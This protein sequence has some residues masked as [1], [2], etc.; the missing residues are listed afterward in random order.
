[1]QATATA[2][3]ESPRRNG[4]LAQ[5]LPGGWLRDIVRS[6][7]DGA[8]M[9][10]R[11]EIVGTTSRALADCVCGRS[12]LLS[13]LGDMPTRAPV[14]DRSSDHRVFDVETE[15]AFKNHVAIILGY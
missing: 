1:M 2:R 4:L 12:N 5:L 8:S 13:M 6:E 11:S 3:V 7:A 10:F 15:H 9:Q 14:T